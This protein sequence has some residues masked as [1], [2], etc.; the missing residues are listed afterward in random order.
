M[1]VLPYATFKFQSSGIPNS[2][3]KDVTLYASELMTFMMPEP[4][5]SNA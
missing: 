1:L 2:S 5:S 3:E 4:R